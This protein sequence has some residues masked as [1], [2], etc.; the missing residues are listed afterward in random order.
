MLADDTA[1]HVIVDM[2]SMYGPMSWLRLHA[3]GKTVI[4]LT[5]APRT[6]ADIRLAQPFDSAS[7]QRLLVELA[8]E[9]A[10]PSSI[11]QPT[12]AVPSGLSAAPEPQDQLPEERPAR[13]D[14]EVAP[15]AGLNAVPVTIEEGLDPDEPA[16]AASSAIMPA[17]T[18]LAAHLRPETTT[19]AKSEPRT[20]TEWLASG[21][22][23][24]R[25]GFERDGLTLFL[26]VDRREYFGPPTLKPLSAHVT[27]DAVAADFADVADWAKKVAGLGAAQPM[28]RL[29]WFGGLM[30]GGGKL[31]PGFDPQARF[32]MLKW[33]QTERE[34]PRHFRIATVM[35]K[36]AAT[37]EEIAEAS[38]V[39]IEDVTDF[40]NANLATG[41][42]E[43]ERPPE[44]EPEPR[45][46]SGL[47]GRF[48]G[49]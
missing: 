39:A 46:P 16:S 10:P 30:S 42:A 26:D 18:N 13:V 33:P 44:P 34:F 21:R 49:R 25:T 4:G 2:D 28:S 12:D 31:L 7:V 45:K 48:R 14:E 8:P 1:D 15:P 27:S 3:A 17:A 19:A 47:F 38:G 29:L 5:S 23:T 20:L 11:T 32:L 22:I 35:M 40:V 37:L 36:G 43:V 24:G 6:Q 9:A 41:F